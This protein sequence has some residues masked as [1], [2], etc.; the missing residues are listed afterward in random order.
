MSV[1]KVANSNNSYVNE[2]K[3]FHAIISCE[4]R[5]G[6]TKLGWAAIHT[7][8]DELVQGCQRKGVAKGGI[9]G[10]GSTYRGRIV[11]H[12]IFEL[13]H[14]GGFVVIKI[15]RITFTLTARICLSYLYLSTVCYYDNGPWRRRKGKGTMYFT[16]SCQV[17][18]AVRTQQVLLLQAFEI[19][20]ACHFQL[21]SSH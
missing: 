4:P 16:P 6:L 1:R 12:E 2:L 3:L 8:L 18:Q 9:G 10:W 17:G 13:W 11:P 19:L 7:E 5:T 14:R 15:K 20:E 21:S